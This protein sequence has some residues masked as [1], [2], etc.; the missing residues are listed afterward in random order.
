MPQFAANLSFLFTEWAFLDRFAAAADAGFRAVEFQFP[1]PFPPDEI[2]RRLASNHL[3]PALFN[4]PPGDF[5]AG[6][7]GLAALPE[8]AAEFRASVALA[9]KYVETIGAPRLHLMSGVADPGDPAAR[10]A[11]ADSL[12]HAVDVLGPRGVDVLIEPLNTRDNPGYF[13]RDFRLAAALIGELALPRL[14]LQFDI[15]HRQILHGD[16]LIGLEAMLPMI[17]H[18]QIASVPDRHEPGTGELNDDLVLRRLDALGY[19]GFVG[20]EYRPAG[21]TPAGLGWFDAWRKRMEGGGGL[22]STRG[23]ETHE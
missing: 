20:C 15:Y 11:Y 6:D 4:F 16:V 14:K 8:R 5:A 1:Y 3:T 13:M 21:S 7:R 22:K 23:E 17:G 2:A 19:A 10:A 9:L 12:R 18:V